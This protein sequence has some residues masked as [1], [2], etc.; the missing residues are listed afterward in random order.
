MHCLRCKGFMMVELTIR[1]NR[2]SMP[3]FELRV[4]IDLATCSAFS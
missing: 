1:W 4:W 2:D 3:L